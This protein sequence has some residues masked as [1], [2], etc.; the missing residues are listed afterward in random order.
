[1]GA[2]RGGGMGQWLG[3]RPFLSQGDKTSSRASEPSQPSQRLFSS[4]LA[5]A[6]EPQG[7]PSTWA[8]G[9]QTKPRAN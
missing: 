2:R 5:Q 3:A 6:S 7:A 9:Y 8:T 1:M 4:A